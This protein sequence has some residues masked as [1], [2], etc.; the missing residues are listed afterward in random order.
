MTSE[1]FADRAWY[2]YH[3]LPRNRRGKPPSYNSL[4][5]KHG[6]STGTISRAMLGDREEFSKTTL[7]KLAR[8]LS[9]SVGWLVEGVGDKPALTGQIPPRLPYLN[10]ANV[11]MDKITLGARRSFDVAHALLEQAWLEAPAASPMELLARAQIFAAKLK[12]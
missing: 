2:A 4:E 10:D 9:V 1:S 7:E 5:E 6:I 8:A 3:C 12:D 11:S